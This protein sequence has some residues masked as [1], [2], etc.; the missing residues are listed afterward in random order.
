VSASRSLHDVV[1]RDA[2]TLSC[3]L[4]VLAILLGAALDR[5]LPAAVYLLSFWHYYLYWLAF[6]RGTIPFDVFKRD[7]VAMK[8]V[9]VAALATVY[10]AAPIDLASLIVIA[11]GILL[12]VRAAAALGIDR[13]YYGHEVAGLPPRRIAAFPYSLTN[14]PMILGNVAAFG[15]TLI[16]PAFRQDWWPL[17][18]LHV[19]LN[20]GLLLMELAGSRRRRAV[21]IG[22]GLAF[23]GVLL[24]A[25]VAVLASA[26]A[27]TMPV[28]LLGVVA[29]G[30]W[31]LHRC[32]SRRTP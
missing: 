8:T 6:T 16:N 15:G 23:A 32:Y 7:A 5:S 1:R 26:A 25:A 24:G 30:A 11:G 3:V 14:H 21:R 22:G 12:N 28:A 27:T 10:L 4:L 2:S 18:A 9:S 13:T 20:I 17:A 19:A 29:A 31:T